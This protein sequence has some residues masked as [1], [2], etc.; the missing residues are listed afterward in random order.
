[1]YPVEVP[2]TEHKYQTIETTG[3][4]HINWY[5]ISSKY[6]Q[7]I[8]YSV[9]CRSYPMWI[10]YNSFPF[11][12]GYNSLHHTCFSVFVE[13]TPMCLPHCHSGFRVQWPSCMLASE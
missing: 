3:K 4:W 5:S 13:V 10:I 1:M 9:S 7:Y 11:V 6:T 8:K 12:E 2:I